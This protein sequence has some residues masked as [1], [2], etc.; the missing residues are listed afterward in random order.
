MCAEIGLKEALE[1]GRVWW[2]AP[3]YSTAGLGFR[4][5]KAMAVKLPMPCIIREADREIIFP[6]SAGSIAFK[7]G[8]RP[9]LL[10]GE[11]LT[12]AIFDEAD[13]IKENV[14]EESIRPALADR[15]GK[16]LIISTPYTIDGWFH[17]LFELGM[18]GTDPNY[19]A[20]QFPSNTN[21]FFPEDEWE[22]LKASTT[23][24]SVWKRE[25]LAQFVG[26]AGARIKREWLKYIEPLEIPRPLR[27]VLGVDLA[28]SEKTLADYTA[29]AAIGYHQPTG[30]LYVLDVWRGRLSFQE[31]IDQVLAM[32]DQYRADTIGV[33][34]A[35]YQ[36]AFSQTLATR[37]TKYAIREITATKDKVTRFAPL[38]SRYQQGLV[39]HVRGIPFDFERELLGFPEVEHDD[40]VDSLSIAWA[41]LGVQNIAPTIRALGNVFDNELYTS[42]KPPREATHDKNP[43]PVPH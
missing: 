37:S 1:G 22:T 12:L 42:K 6:H 20:W 32:A 40:Q 34:I 10:R 11:S 31:Q 15:L 5:V 28:I 14:W 36:R 29:V 3:S 2:I 30:N 33:E 16:A 25:Y 19:K 8:E 43:F 41:A 7:S 23:H 9:E 26:D 4:E 18:A 24:E 39:T 21:P 17:K 13:F 35:G 38:E 27:V